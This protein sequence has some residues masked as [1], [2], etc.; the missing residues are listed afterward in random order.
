VDPIG[1]YRADNIWLFDTRI[2]KVFKIGERL[3]ADVF[4]DAFNILNSN[5][6]QTADNTTGVKTA[7][8]EGVN[9]TY[10]RFLSPTSLIPPRVFRLGARFTF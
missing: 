4:F 6:R 5:A 8:V 2:Q 9:Y 10:Q 1:S 7:T 3:R